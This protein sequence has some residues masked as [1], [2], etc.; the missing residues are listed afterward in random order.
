MSH[1]KKVLTLV[2]CSLC[3]TAV[4]NADL[5][6]ATVDTGR[7]LNESK[8]AAGK[9]KEL[10]ALSQDAKKKAD[11]KKKALQAMETKLKEKHVTEDSKE[12]DNFRNEAKEYARFIKDTE[13]DLKKRYLKLNKEMA[14]RTLTKIA[15]YAKANKIDLVL[16][17]SDKYQGPLLYGVPSVDITDAILGNS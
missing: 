16:D 10:D 11:D 4:A 17:K 1:I 5:K 8:D 13:E 15:E 6:I 7:I 3:T 2:V 9:K 12:A 14:D